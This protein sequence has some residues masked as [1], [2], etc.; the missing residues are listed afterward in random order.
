MSTETAF[1]KLGCPRDLAY[2][3]ETAMIT[4]GI[5][6]AQ[7]KAH[8]AAQLAHETQGFTRFEENLN[9]SAKRLREVFRKYFPTDTLANQYANHKVKIGN[10]VYANRMGNGNEASGDGYKY[11][12]RTAIHLTGKENYSRAS[13]AI[14][15]DDRLVDDPDLALDPGISAK[16][17]VWYWNWKECCGPSRNNDIATVTYRING[18]YNGL[19]E[20]KEWL[21]KAA[22]VFG[23]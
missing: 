1:D 14:F 4:G 7:E 23:L 6:S 11:R 10:R 21:K 5:V 9:Y 18:G 20:R 22:K 13:Q 17:A 15:G 3:L 16:I 12:G 8:F 19:N 2:A